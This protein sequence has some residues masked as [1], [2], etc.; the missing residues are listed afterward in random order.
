MGQ[1]HTSSCIRT[2]NSVKVSDRATLIDFLHKTPCYH[3]ATSNRNAYQQYTY[4]DGIKPLRLMDCPF[5]DEIGWIKGKN[6]YL[7][8]LGK[9]IP[10][11][12]TKHAHSRKKPYNQIVFI[13]QAFVPLPKSLYTVY[14]F[15]N[16]SSQIHHN[17]PVL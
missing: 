5:R 17:L 7:S 11:K 4:H 13:S 10:R 14:I 12:S 16:S 15:F 2:F 8:T 9:Q 1:M 6:N 3:I